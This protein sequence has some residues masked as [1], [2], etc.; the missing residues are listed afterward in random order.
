M[1]KEEV[2]QLMCN[3]E[4]NTL[5]SK[6]RQDGIEVVERDFC[7][8]LQDIAEKYFYNERNIYYMVTIPWGKIKCD[9]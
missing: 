4:V 1:S 6:L 5:I 8:V 3:G 7:S 9:N 2:M